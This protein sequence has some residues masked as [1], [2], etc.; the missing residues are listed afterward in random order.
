MLFFER[1]ENLKYR[2]NSIRYFLAYTD[3]YLALADQPT[4]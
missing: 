4:N 3:F 2:N 1:Q